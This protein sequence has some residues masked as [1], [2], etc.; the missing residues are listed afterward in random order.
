MWMLRS[1][2]HQCW[3]VREQGWQAVAFRRA[4]LRESLKQPAELIVA[5]ADARVE[6]A[7][8]EPIDPVARLPLGSPSNVPMFLLPLKC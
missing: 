7:K 3:K 5:H 1:S 2:M 8:H 4:D 6:D